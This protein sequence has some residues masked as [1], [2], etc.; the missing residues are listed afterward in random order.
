MMVVRRRE[1]FRSLEV[2]FIKLESEVESM[3]TKFMRGKF[4][5]HF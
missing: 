1:S 3:D 5:K 4:M 2:G